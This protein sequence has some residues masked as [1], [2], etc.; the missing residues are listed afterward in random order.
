[1]NNLL[2]ENVIQLYKNKSDCC[3]C[4]AC[5][6]ICPK[7][8]IEM[9]EDEYGFIYPSINTDLC[10]KCGKCRTVCAFQ[11]IEEKNTAKAV[12]AAS[13]KDSEKILKSTS[14]GV[15]AVLAEKVIENQG[16][17]FG[18]SME[19]IDN[20]LVPMHI[21]VDNK[22]DLKK[23]Q[24]SKYVQSFM[25]HAYKEAEKYLQ[26][27]K[28]V[29]FS[30]TPCQIAGLKAF[31]KK[32]YNNLITVDI[33][34]HGV[35][36]VKM[37]HDYIK[38]CE[39]RIKGKIKSIKF[40]DKEQGWDH[41]GK[42]K[43]TNKFGQDKEEKLECI[44]SSYYM[45][46]LDGHINR[47]NCRKCKYT[48]KHRPGDITIGDY[49]GIEEEHSQFLKKNGGDMDTEKGISCVIINTDKGEKFF[50]D[51]KNYFY[52]HESEF[53]KAAKRNVQLRQPCI[54]RKRNRILNNYRK[55]GYEF[56]EIKFQIRLRIKLLYYKLF[57]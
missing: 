36:S 2:K 33:V 24:G 16:I 14:G 20:Q 25:G 3:A 48:S 9:K 34:C 46:F 31:L 55:F 50:N 17:V 51:T 37:F 11:N 13:R 57:R 45:M 28:R 56:L 35:P 42:L 6:N 32:E 12:Y 1:M 4:G 30:G 47:E 8:A 27:G 41:V 52:I 54:S 15:F 38:L 7:S 53:E 21:S 5:M 18:A 39:K 26:E 23:L 44:R 19:Y 29:L 10:I 22:E 40:R 43:Y 49:W